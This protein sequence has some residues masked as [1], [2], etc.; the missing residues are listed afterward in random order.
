MTQV[1]AAC[2]PLFLDH[3]DVA[4]EAV[5]VHFWLSTYYKT[6][7][8]H[9][10]GV[11]P[12]LSYGMTVLQATGSGKTLAF[13]VPIVEILLA[14][15]PTNKWQIGA[16]VIS[17]TRELALQTFTVLQ[18]LQQGTELTSLLLVGGSDAAD[19]ATKFQEH[20]G[21]IIIATPGRLEDSFK[22]MNQFRTGTKNLEVLVLDEADKLLAMGFEQSISA[23]LTYLP[24][25]RRTVC[26]ALQQNDIAGQD[27][28]LIQSR[29]RSP[30]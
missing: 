25:Q 20:G 16:I 28:F 27:C 10:E 15:P 26:W 13:L 21:N 6:P 11:L 12:E 2:I 30:H 29:L 22:R 7:A 24:K 18:E 4:V 5:S 17:P 23:I 19:D 14:N 8:S 9:F 1:Q 3:K